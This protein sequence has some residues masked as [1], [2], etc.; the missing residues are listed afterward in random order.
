MPE[1][2]TAMCIVGA[3]PNLVKIAPILH[4]LEADG[5]LRPLLVHTGQHYD[6]AMADVFFSDLEMA[7]PAVNLGAGSGTH[8]VQTGVIMQALERL[9]SERKPAIIVTVG[10]VN[11]TLA[12]ALVAAKAGVRQAHVEAGLR[13]GDAKMPEEVNR[14]VTDRLADLLFTHSAEADDNLVSEGVAKFR[15]HMVGNV[16]IDSL[17]RLRPKWQNAAKL[18][19][20]DLPQRYAVLTLH[21]PS[22]VDDPERFERLLKGL[23]NAATELPMVFPVH[24]RTRSRLPQAL[25]PGLR[26]VDPLGYLAFLDLIEHASAVLTDSGGIQEETTVL[27]IPCLTLRTST[28]RPVTI[29]LGTNRLVGDDPEAIAPAL[30]AA[31]GSPA[32]PGDIPQWDGH[33]A[34]RIVRVLVAKVADPLPLRL[35]HD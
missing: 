10:D 21:R 24:P 7:Q 16:M 34:E 32:I 14:V 22:N 6:A 30:I 35:A 11:S 19:V 13:S 31:L 5:R 9:V 15:I 8:A 25:P 26:M 3:R 17:V 2:P 12:A 4:A 1:R 29:R 28:E 20:P 18:A 27:G 33:A 23:S